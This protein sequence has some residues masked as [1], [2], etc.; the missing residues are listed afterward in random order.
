M[1]S[2]SSVE[3]SLIKTI[4]K[5]FL[6]LSEDERLIEISRQLLSQDFSFDPLFLFSQ[7]TTTSQMSFPQFISFLDNYLNI[8]NNVLAKQL[9]VLYDKERKQGLSFENVSNIFL[10]KNNIELKHLVQDRLGNSINKKFGRATIPL[11]KAVI[12]R[13]MNLISHFGTSMGL[14]KPQYHNM[15]NKSIF[16]VLLYFS[17]SN[18]QGLT[19]N[20]LKDLLSYSKL[21]FDDEV[22]KALM[23][24]LDRDEDGIITLCDFEHIIT[25]VLYC[26][27]AQEKES[28]T[29]NYLK[30]INLRPL[31][32]TTS[33]NNVSQL[34]NLCKDYFNALM[35]CEEE[36]EKAKINLS[37]RS[38]F[39]INDAFTLFS[40]STDKILLSDL[41]KII[42]GNFSKN[43]IFSHQDME[44]IMKRSDLVHKGYIDK[45]DFFDLLTPFEKEYRDMVEKRLANNSLYNNIS[46]SQGTMLYLNNL[47]ESIVT[48]ER[49]INNIRYNISPYRNE[50]N[51]IFYEICGGNNIEFFTIDNLHNY[52]CKNNIISY[53]DKRFK[54]VFIKFDRNRTG[55]IE[56][57]EFLDEITYVI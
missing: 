16:D 20:D 56:F 43:L 31:P 10:S 8:H 5:I 21:I 33:E 7:I 39:N 28:N 6:K 52:F 26:D 29:T 44:L 36:I 47:F 24:R 30:G 14:L 12:E 51:K 23:R 57:F 48:N 25:S 17:S 42:Y 53:R 38:D 15:S 35:D 22:I 32:G 19:E 41:E 1:N 27:N 49:K 3:N 11:M 34:K 46:L 45:A 54:L 18:S 9:F 40:S 13:E 55:K 37:L 4:S 50:L 2:I